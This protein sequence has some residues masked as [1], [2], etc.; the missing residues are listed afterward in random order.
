[1]PLFPG[2]CDEIARRYVP[3]EIAA[4]GACFWQERFWAVRI[5]GAGVFD[6][7]EK[8]TGEPAGG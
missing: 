6:S 7:G 4:K 1:M 3:Q 5:E 8:V 2:G